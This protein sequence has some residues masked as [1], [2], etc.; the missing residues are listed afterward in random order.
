MYY[1]DRSA[2]DIYA[3]LEDD[4]VGDIIGHLEI[5]NSKQKVS[6]N[7]KSKKQLDDII[8]KKNIYY[9]ISTKCH[10]LKIYYI[11]RV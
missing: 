5:I 8:L 7:K 6:W 10:L 4:E 9:H 2:G 11:K 3:K 1:I